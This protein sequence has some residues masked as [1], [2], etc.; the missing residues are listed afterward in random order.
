MSFSKRRYGIVEGPGELRESIYS[1]TVDL[2]KMPL[3]SGAYL[4]LATQAGA[5]KL[6]HH[7]LRFPLQEGDPAPFIPT[8]YLVVNPNASDLRL[9]RRWPADNFSR[10][11]E[12]LLKRFPG[13]TV[14][15]T[16]SAS[17]CSHVQSVL[18]NI[19]SFYSNRLMDTSGKLSM[20][21]FISLVSRAEL[22]ITNDSGPMHLAMALR[23]PL[24]A[25]FG[26][27][28]PV[29]YAMPGN[30]TIL[31]KN[32][33]CSPCVHLHPVSPCGGDNQCMKQISVR[34]VVEACCKY[35]ETVQETRVPATTW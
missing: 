19:H 13:H 15:L 22:M 24:V 2:K 35:L 8:P 16:G 32:Y 5:V 33:P 20:Q 1:S 12:S 25:L 28:S 4:S 14:V 26:P 7:L 27:G 10:L 11:I 9:E 30:A 17:E 18:Q 23:T 3:L 31:Y 34:E 6:H 21:E 29:H